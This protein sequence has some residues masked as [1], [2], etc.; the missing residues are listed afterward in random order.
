MGEEHVRTADDI[1][2]E[3][4]V[5]RPV[6]SRAIQRRRRRV[7][8]VALEG[9]VGG[10]DA[11]DRTDVIE[12]VEDLDAEA[13]PCI[14]GARLADAEVGV[15]VAQHRFAVEEDVDRQRECGRSQAEE[16]GDGECGDG[17]RG[18]AIR[19]F[20]DHDDSNHER[21][22]SSSAADRCTGRWSFA[23]GPGEKCQENQFLGGFCVCVEN[24]CAAVRGSCSTVP[25]AARSE[26]GPADATPSR[27][28]PSSVGA[29]VGTNVSGRLGEVRGAG[30]P[31]S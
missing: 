19:G 13:V 27:T 16:R 26:P 5:H 9:L 25:S 28:I 18:S 29:W 24:G 21:E 4:V 20:R 12:A 7:G 11:G 14:E 22:Q 31:G 23:V 10:E 15:G 30:D 1:G 3:D 2:A 8:G 17:K 6:R